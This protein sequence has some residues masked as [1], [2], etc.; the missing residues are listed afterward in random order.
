MRISPLY[1]TIIVIVSCESNSN[2]FDVKSSEFQKKSSHHYSELFVDS[3]KILLKTNS[4]EDG[5]SQLAGS[6]ASNK[7][8]EIQDQLHNEGFINSLINWFSD[9]EPK[10]DLDY[11]ECEER[12]YSSENER[13]T[14]RLAMNSLINERNQLLRQLDSLQTNLTISRRTSNNQIKQIE[15]DNNKLQTLIDILSREIE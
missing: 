5:E 9:S 2:R 12:L 6:I 15:V 1:L 3:S 14:Q 4:E 13:N 7:N 10:L 11:N 8:F